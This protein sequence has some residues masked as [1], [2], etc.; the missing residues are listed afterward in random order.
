MVNF[1]QDWK[2][3][4]LLI[5]RSFPR[6]DGTGDPGI[7]VMKV[8][9]IKV[10]YSYI[11]YKLRISRSISSGILIRE[12]IEIPGTGK[13]IETYSRASVS[14]SIRTMVIQACGI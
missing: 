6:A 7:R 11:F 9:Y 3:K 2:R 14:W 10:G 13:L 1:Y 12:D 5:R 8:F 4:N